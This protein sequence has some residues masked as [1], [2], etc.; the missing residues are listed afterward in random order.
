M[1]N[2]MHAMDRERRRG[3][4]G[5]NGGACLVANPPPPSLITGLT[6]ET[7]TVG[8]NLSKTA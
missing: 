1:K 4:R 7:S 5:K 3:E 8:R 6:W 2:E